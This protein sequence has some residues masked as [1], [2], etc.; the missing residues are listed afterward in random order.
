MERALIFWWECLKDAWRGSLERANAWSWIV[1]LAV[2]AGGARLSGYQLKVPEDVQELFAYGIVLIGA[3]L[4]VFFCIRLLGAPTRLYW[5]ERDGRSSCEASFDALAAPDADWRIHEL[6]SHIQPD[7]LEQPDEH[8]WERIGNDIRDEFSL[9]RLKVWGR[10]P[11]SGIGAV[12]KERPALRPIEPIYWHSAHFTYHFFDDS[13]VNAPHTYMEPDS[14]L[15][16]YTDLRV[17]RAQAV[18][19]WPGPHRIT[20]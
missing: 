10:P 15:P 7:L 13:A 6:F 4:I 12:L 17:N 8:A 2:V 18:R 14:E 5:R 3:A 16:I 11:T 20:K 19:M 9:G 1:G